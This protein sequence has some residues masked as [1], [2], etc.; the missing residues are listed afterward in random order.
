MR[1]YRCGTIGCSTKRPRREEHVGRCSRVSVDE[2]PAGAVVA[3]DPGSVD[4]DYDN[5]AVAFTVHLDSEGGMEML[6]SG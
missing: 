4:V 6:G 1:H 2:A 5:G 3:T